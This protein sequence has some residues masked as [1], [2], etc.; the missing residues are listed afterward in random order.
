[1]AD[2]SAGPNGLHALMRGYDADATAAARHELLL[3]RL[4]ALTRVVILCQAASALALHWRATG[5]PLAVAGILVLLVLDNAALVWC[6]LRRGLLDSRGPATLDVF[7][8]MA[9]LVAAVALLRPAANPNTDNILYPYTVTV[10]LVIGLACRRLAAAATAAALASAVYVSA[11]AMRFGVGSS[12]TT[13]ANAT[14]YWAWA[15]GGW[16]V[17]DRFRVL[18]AGLDEARQAAAA[19]GAKLAQER[20]RSRHARELLAV[21][22]AAAQHELERE[23]ER[24][25]LSRALHDHV[26]QTLEFMGKDGQLADP[27]LRDTVAAEAAWLRGLVRGELDPGVDTLP[28]ALDRV[29]EEQTRAGMRIELNTSGLGADQ[30]PAQAVRAIAGAVGELLTNVRKHAGTGRAVLRAV[31]AP[32]QVTVTVLDHGCGFDPAAVAEGVG[33]RES[34]AARVREAGGRVLVTSEP[35]AGTHVEIVVPREEGAVI[36]AGERAALAAEETGVPPAGGRAAITGDVPKRR[37][38]PAGEQRGRIPG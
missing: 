2:R 16:F 37:D 34:V 30:L 38:V 18:S 22:M 24:V 28:A 14:T 1:M 10:V 11:T 23:R 36:P 3:V 5:H 7:L 9:A 32:G 12:A 27:L 8:G 13:I 26:L 25:R 19:Q 20:E 21:R 31:S 35:G 29:A 15:I 4:L 17:A 33:L 6:C